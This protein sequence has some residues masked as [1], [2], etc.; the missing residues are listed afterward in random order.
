MMHVVYLIYNLL[1]FFP[2]KNDV[3]NEKKLRE[4]TM[5]HILSLCSKQ[6]INI[7]N[8]LSHSD[9]CSIFTGSNTMF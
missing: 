5:H 1:I 7:F 8:F 3:R 2:K 6:I 9:R 4:N